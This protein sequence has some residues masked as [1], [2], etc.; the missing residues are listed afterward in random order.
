MV[1]KRKKFIKKI[2]LPLIYITIKLT[3]LKN[4]NNNNN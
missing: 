2:I 4:N 1:N 3:Y